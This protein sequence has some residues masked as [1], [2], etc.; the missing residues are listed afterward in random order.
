MTPVPQTMCDCIASVTSPEGGNHNLQLAVAINIAKNSF[1]GKKMMADITHQENNR[2]Y[3]RRK[4]QSPVQVIFLL[5]YG[6]EGGNQRHGHKAIDNGIGFC[7][8]VYIKTK[9]NIQLYSIEHYNRHKYDYR[10]CDNEQIGSFII[11]VPNR[12]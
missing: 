6:D 10:K 2:K 7:K 4:H 1:T 9:I 3:Q 5:L 12:C 11:F 8:K